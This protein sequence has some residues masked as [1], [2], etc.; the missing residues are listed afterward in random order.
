MGLPFHC[1]LSIR[2]RHLRDPCR[3]LATKEDSEDEYPRKHQ[4]RETPEANETVYDS[5]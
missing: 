5:T 2:T 3:G 1:T 4:M